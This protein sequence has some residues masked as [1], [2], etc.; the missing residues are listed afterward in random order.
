MSDDYI[1]V[2]KNTFSIELKKSKFISSCYFVSN[3]KE[4]KSIILKVK[5]AFHD[6]SHHVYS[7]VLLDGKS[8]SCDDH[9]P[10][11][12]AGVQVLK[13]IQKFN[14]KN[15]LILVIRYF[16]GIK[17]GTGGLSRAY[18]EAAEKLIE[19]TKLVIKKMCYEINFQI[20]YGEYSK[21][22]Y[23]NRYKITGTKFDFDVEVTFAIEY[24]KVEIFKKSDIILK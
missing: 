15:T 12:T 21:I 8:K 3:E 16:G 10:S 5:S 24:N 23:L 18:F 20:N 9:E 7:Y 22:V 14:L 6:A 4:A 17:L 19:N 2:S 11:G 1:T 13:A